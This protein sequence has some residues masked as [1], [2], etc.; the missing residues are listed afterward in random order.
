[1]IKRLYNFISNP[2]FLSIGIAF[3]ILSIML[4]FWVTRL[5]LIK[6]AL[7]L[8]DGDLGLAL[9]FLPVGSLVS[10]LVSSRFVNAIGDGKAA[11]LSLVLFSFSVVLPFL[12]PSFVILCALL[13]VM[14]FL[15]GL[16]DIS[17]NAVTGIIEQQKGTIIMSTCHGF[18][19]LGG[20]IGAVLAS[21]LIGLS[22]D[23]IPQILVTSIIV[24]ITTVLF[25][26]RHLVHVKSD[27]QDVD[28]PAFAIPTKST[29]WL[30]IIGFCIMISEG[31]V[32]DWSTIYMEDFLKADPFIV[33]F[34][35][36]GFSL[37]M[38]LGRFNGDVIVSKIG[39]NKTMVYGCIIASLGAVLVV[40]G[41]VYI[42][43]VGFSLIGLGFSTIVPIL[44]SRAAKAEGTSPAHGVAAVA[45]MGY[46]GFLLGPVV[47]GIIADHYG[48]NMSFAMLIVL[49]FISLGAI[50]KAFRRSAK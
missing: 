26:Y 20:M 6:S 7:N 42:S 44:F 11:L 29:I 25:L 41:Q 49:T 5:P 31:A 38:T 1:M 9:F 45:G 46:I 37:F 30:A 19:S 8:T 40:L 12:A 43:I 15:L 23:P 34:G 4:A 32:M 27:H 21:M 48:L 16:L 28:D 36:A 17:I 35:Y 50:Q 3:A 18:F 24:L 22:I 33:G 39:E 47:I 13:L 14:G 2:I 10:M